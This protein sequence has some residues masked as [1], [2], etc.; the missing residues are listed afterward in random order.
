MRPHPSVFTRFL[1]TA[2]AFRRD[3]DD[4]G[5]AAAMTPTPTSAMTITTTKRTFQISSLLG[6]VS[7][8]NRR[9][10]GRPNRNAT[11]TMTAPPIT[12]AIA[13]W[14]S[15]AA[16]I[17]TSPAQE[18]VIQAGPSPAVRVDRLT[19]K[20][21]RVHSGFLEGSTKYQRVDVE[22]PRDRYVGRW[23][24]RLRHCLRAR[25]P[26]I[27]RLRHQALLPFRAGNLTRARR[28]FTSPRGAPLS[29]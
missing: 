26:V 16:R 11:K 23:E 24:S 10:T 28:I 2:A 25:P 17:E 22:K 14:P 7:T 27:G 9:V 29:R 13:G 19:C 12:S 8:A 15:T 5:I 6:S 3:Q 20:M 21:Y 4:G 18:D 1:H